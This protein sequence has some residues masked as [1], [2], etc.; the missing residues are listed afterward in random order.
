MFTPITPEGATMTARF[1]TADLDVLDCAHPVGAAIEER[2]SRMS[3]PPADDPKRLAFLLRHAVDA[4]REA[5]AC[6]A[7]LLT[8]DLRAHADAAPLR[9]A[10]ALTSAAR[11]RVETVG[12]AAVASLG[13]LPAEP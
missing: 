13:A 8:A 7:R 10:A 11:T 5:D 12:S 6:L 1:L 2:T 4:L 3:L 9:A